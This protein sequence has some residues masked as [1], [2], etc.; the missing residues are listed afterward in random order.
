MTRPLFKRRLSG[1]AFC[2]A[3]TALIAGSPALKAETIGLVVTGGWT[4]SGTYTKDMKLECPNGFNPDTRDNYRSLK[5]KTEAEKEADW[6]GNTSGDYRVVGSSRLHPNFAPHLIKEPLPYHD[7]LGKVSDGFNLDGTPDG[8]ATAG[9]CTHEKMTSPD[10]ARDIDNQL[11]R[12]AACTRGLRADGLLFQFWNAEFVTAQEN[13]WLVEISNVD[14]PANDDDVVVMISH[15]LDKIVKDANGKFVIGMSQRIDTTLP[16]YLTYT[17]GRI[18]DHE[19]IT[20]PIPELSLPA[21]AL[22]EIAEIRFLDARM[23]L[24][25]TPDGA[26]GILGAYHDTD[27]LH[28]FYAKTMGMHTIAAGM[29]TVSLYHALKRNA[30]GVRDPKTGQCSAISS[31]YTVELVRASIV[32]DPNLPPPPPITIAKNRDGAGPRTGAAEASR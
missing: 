30:D 28:R 1:V 18:V 4:I 19:L 23:R 32:R 31:A 14:D 15:G 13:R 25:L 29:P 24:K 20:D 17:T 12:A 3:M 2:A 22:T 27:R 6:I 5:F 21:F 8:A 10:G 26:K 11:Y 9:T 7:A 16:Q